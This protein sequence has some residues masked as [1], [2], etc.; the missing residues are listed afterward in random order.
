M[1][2]R[3][4]SVQIRV[5]PAAVPSSGHLATPRRKQSQD[6]VAGCE[7]R[8][9]ANLAEA[10]TNLTANGRRR[11]EMSAAA[12]TERA[13]L[14]QRIHNSFEKR[15]ALDAAEWERADADEIRAENGRTEFH[16]VLA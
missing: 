3:D 6:T 1:S 8:A 14:L 2:N 7:E 13:S 4:A 12:W 10:A 5:S 16:D 9:A 11:L 15:K